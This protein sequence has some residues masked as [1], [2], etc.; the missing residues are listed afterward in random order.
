LGCI[1]LGWT[2]Y[3][4]VKEFLNGQGGMGWGGVGWGYP[5]IPANG[6]CIT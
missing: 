1:G 4:R 6:C 5:L 2:S 3:V